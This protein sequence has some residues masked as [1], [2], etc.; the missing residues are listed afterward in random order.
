MEDFL[1]TRNGKSITTGLGVTIVWA[2]CTPIFDIL[3]NGHI[4]E[5]NVYKFVIEPIVIGALVGVFEYFFQMSK[6]RKNRK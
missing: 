5:W 3:F 6:K 2:I 1:K 4:G